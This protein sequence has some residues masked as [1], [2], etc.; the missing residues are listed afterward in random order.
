MPYDISYY[1][2]QIGCLYKGKYSGNDNSFI[3]IKDVIDRKNHNGYHF[4]YEVYN[5]PTGS[6]GS[7]ETMQ[8]CGYFLDNCKKIS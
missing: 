5:Y 2:D 4:V 1:Y 3:L 6:G 8:E 7:F